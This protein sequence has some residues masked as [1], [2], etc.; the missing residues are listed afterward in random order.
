M[1]FMKDAAVSPAATKNENVQRIV[2]NFLF[3]EADVDL[4]IFF[5]FAFLLLTLN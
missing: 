1:R 4:N 2:E 5:I 3:P